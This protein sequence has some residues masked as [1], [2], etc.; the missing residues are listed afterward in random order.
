MMPE[1]RRILPRASGRCKIAMQTINPQNFHCQL[2]Q[3]Q[4]HC[5]KFKEIYVPLSYSHR[6]VSSFAA[7]GLSL[8]GAAMYLFPWV[9][10]SS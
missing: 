8:S 10:F 6:S 9:A 7:R 2:K 5:F 1:Y 3:L 4:C